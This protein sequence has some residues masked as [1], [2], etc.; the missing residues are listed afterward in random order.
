[1]GRGE[2]DDGPMIGLLTLTTIDG[3]NDIEIVVDK[4]GGL[5]GRVSMEGGVPLTA[6]GTRLALVRERFTP[7]GASDDVIEIAP[8]GWLEAGNLIGEYRVRV[9]EPQR[10]TVKAVRRRGMRVT[11][12][13]LVIRNAEILDEVEILIGPR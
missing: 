11:N 12:D 1:M 10:W 13:R 4:P 9:D 5:R 8:D 7:L 2:N 6:V 3:P